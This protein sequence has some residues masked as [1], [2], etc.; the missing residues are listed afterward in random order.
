MWAIVDRSAEF[1]LEGLFEERQSVYRG[2]AGLT[3]EEFGLWYNE[4]G[5]KSVPWMELVDLSKWV[6]GVGALRPVMEGPLGNGGVEM[7]KKP[8]FCFQISESANPVHLVISD[9]DAKAVLDLVNKTGLC[10]R[11]PADVCGTLVSVSKD[12]MLSKAAFD[13]CIRD[14]VPASLLD[15]EEKTSFSVLLSSIFFSFDRENRRELVC[16]GGCSADAIELASGFSLLCAGS[17]SA[18]L[19]FAFALHDEDGDERLTRRG[20][21]RYT[22]SFLTALMALSFAS[23]SLSAE[24]L[25]RAVDD[26]AVWTSAAIFAETATQTPNRIGFDEFAAWYT[27][28]GFRV[29]PWLE[30]LDMG[31]W[32][33]PSSA[34]P[35][36]GAVGSASE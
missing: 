10:Q 4:G 28:G 24:E 12:G 21:W 8:R 27:E 3:F 23:S 15:T 25:T 20:L 18:K 29:S 31:K 6:P 14:M 13:K 19:A 17:K 1:T 5:F 16:G 34:V 35:L 22:R 36:A 26:G 33:V 32:V 30:L 2:R 9:D 7:E 11:E